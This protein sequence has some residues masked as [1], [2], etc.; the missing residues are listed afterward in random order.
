[1]SNLVE[2][3][4]THRREARLLDAFPPPVP[5]DAATGYAIQDALIARLPGRVASWKVAGVRPE[6][7]ET[8]GEPRVVAFAPAVVHADGTEVVRLAGIKGTAHAVE[9]EFAVRLA[10]D[11]AEDADA[12]AILAAIGEVRCAVEV[13]G[14]VVPG[15]S[16]LGPAAAIADHGNCLFIV[17]GPRLERWPG[18]AAA[19][20]VTRIS[21]NGGA[22][23]T[24]GVD[25]LEGGMV[26]ALSFLN[27]NLRSRG[28]VLKAGDWVS[29]GATSG[30]H[31]IS[32]GDTA[33]IEWANDHSLDVTIS[34]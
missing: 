27:A 23:V 11:L 2:T 32:P 24:G 17:L 10:H 6:D 3:L 7:R 26:G 18:I 31:P 29:T 15:L 1:M 13:C 16:A 25:R 19:D 20:M 14:S 12:D 4:I 22:A 30:S 8:F 33:R 28:H 9:A 21:I 34:V 5:Q